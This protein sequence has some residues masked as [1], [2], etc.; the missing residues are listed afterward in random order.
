MYR[1]Y[2]EDEVKEAVEGLEEAKLN[3]DIEDVKYWEEE[4]VRLA[5]L[6]TP[7]QHIQIDNEITK[8]TLRKIIKHSY[9]DFDEYAEMEQPLENI[10]N[11]FVTKVMLEQIIKRVFRVK[12]N[13]SF[14]KSTK[15]MFTTRNKARFIKSKLE[16]LLN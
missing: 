16:E 10:D 15:D 4:L 6:D 12:A 5:P 8:N 9:W 14:P 3:N 1:K 11:G 13:G 7:Y 2:I